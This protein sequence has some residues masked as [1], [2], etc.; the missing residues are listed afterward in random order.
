VSSG[1]RFRVIAAATCA[2]RYFSTRERRSRISGASPGPRGLVSR[3]SN[4]LALG[5][6]NTHLDRQFL[7]QRIAQIS[8]DRIHQRPLRLTAQLLIFPLMLR[9]QTR[10]IPA[11]IAR[12]ASTA[13]RFH[14]V[15]QNS[16]QQNRFAL[17]QF[18]VQWE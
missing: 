9:I 7:Q 6:G 8:R 14:H 10:T 13:M 3:T 2:R 12:A 18:N 11:R 15:L 17:S 16:A 5:A 1:A 4:R